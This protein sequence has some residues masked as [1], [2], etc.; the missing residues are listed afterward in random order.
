MQ[1]A[2]Q[3]AGSSDEKY[4]LL[5]MAAEEG[6]TGESKKKVSNKEG[7]AA[8]SN[9][10]TDTLHESKP[11]QDCG[12]REYEHCISGAEI[13]F[14]AKEMIGLPLPHPVS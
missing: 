14:S 6:F 13:Q 11:K 3:G 8:E 5:E 1:I 10:C 12:Q 9:R 4:W 2:R 7:V